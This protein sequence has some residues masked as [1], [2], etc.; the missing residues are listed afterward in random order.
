MSKK[1][2]SQEIDSALADLPPWRLNEKRIERELKFGS[3]AEAF[4]FMTRVSFE[5]EKMNHHP[6][7]FN[8]YNRVKIELTTHDSGGLTEKDFELARRIERI[9]WTTT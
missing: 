5:A 7:W 9:N 8:S 3:F 4:S 2:S 6:D 1:L